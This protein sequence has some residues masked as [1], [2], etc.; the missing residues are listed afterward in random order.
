MNRNIR[1]KN[2]YRFLKYK[3]YWV[4]FLLFVVPIYAQGP[5]V[6]DKNYRPHPIGKNL[7]IFEDK[8]GDVNIDSILTGKYESLFF[9]SEEDV[10]SF[11][12]STS[13]FWLRF[14]LENRVTKRSP[15]VVDF[16][17]PNIHYIDYYQVSPKNEI[18]KS[19]H[20]GTMKPLSS[21]EFFYHH[22]IFFIQPSNNKVDQVYIRIESGTAKPASIELLSMDDFM[23]NAQSKAA[24]I[25][26][27]IGILLIMAGYNLFLFFSLKDK[28]YLYFSTFIAFFLF[29]VLSYKGVAQLY[30]WPDHFFWGKIAVPMFMVLSLIF[31]LKF[32][33]SFLQLKKY[34]IIFRHSFILLQVA[35]ILLLIIIPFTE[36]HF[37]ILPVNILILITSVLAVTV[38]VMAWRKGSRPAGFFLLSILFLL[39]STAMII[40]IRLN[41]I[42][43]N[44][45]TEEGIL[46]GGVSM[47]LLMSLALADRIKMLHSEKEEM[48][49]NLKSS[50]D[51][52]DTLI[53]SG[54]D[55][56]WEI[57]KIGAYTFASKNVQR[58]LGYEPSEIIGKTP[59]DLMPEKEAHEKKMIFDKI[60]AKRSPIVRLENIN[61]KKNGE[62]IILETNG[63]PFFDDNGNLLGYRGVDRDIT[64]ERHNEEL[65]DAIFQISQATDRANSLE[66]L[67]PEIHK[68]IMGIM[69]AQNFYISLYVEKIDMI[70]FP[71]FVDEYSKVAQSRKFGKG[72]TEYVLKTGKSYLVRQPENIKLKQDGEIVQM[73]QP[74]ALWLGVP[75]L[76][77]EKPIGVMAVQ[78]YTNPDAYS[79]K[80][81]KI[82]E[83]VSQQVALSIRKKQIEEQIRILS[84]SVEQSP[85]IVIITD[86]NGDIEYV[87]K[88]FVEVTGYGLDEVIGE[89]PRILKSDKT[90]DAVY[91]DMWDTITDGKEWQGEF[92]NKKKNGKIYFQASNVT[93]FTDEKGEVSHFLALAEDI[94]ESRHQEQIRKVMNNISDAVS[95]TPNLQEFYRVVHNELNELLDATNF[96]VGIYEEKTDSIIL[97]FSVDEKDAIE[98]APAA[99]TLS[100]YV[101]KNNQA[102]LLKEKEM[103]ELEAKGLIGHVGSDCKV[104]LGVP[105]KDDDQVTGVIVVQSYEDENAYDPGDLELMEFVAMQVSI[106]LKQKQIEDRIH[107]LSLSVEQSPATVMITDVDGHIEYVNRKFSQISGYESTEVIGKNPNIL[108]SGKMSDS[109][110][111]E[112]WSTIKNGKEWR[113]E[114]QNRKKNGD[115]YWE[116]IHISPIIND[117]GEIIRFLAVKEDISDRIELQDQLAQSQKMEAVGNLAGGI[118][119]DFNNLLTVI[120][121]YSEMA[122][123]KIEADTELHKDILAIQSA[124]EKA[125]DLTR[126]ILGFSRKQIYQPEIISLNNSITGLNEMIRRLIGEDIKIY[127]KLSSDLSPIKADARQIEQILINLIIN[128]R[129]AINLKTEKASEKKI[130]VETDKAFLDESFV[131]TH[132]GSQRGSHI[133]LSISDSGIGMS[134]EVKLNIFEPFFTTKEKEQG[135]GLGLATVYGIVKQNEGSIFVY[136]EPGKGS[137]FNIYWPASE[138][139]EFQFETK[140]VYEKDQFW[141]GESILYVEDD[142]AIQRFAKNALRKFGYTVYLAENGR[143]A[144]DFL[145]GNKQKIDLLIT[146]LIMPEMNGKELADQV[147]KI[148]PSI[149]VLFVSGY[150]DNHIVNGGQL[151][152]GVEFLQ[153]PYTVNSLLKK[154]RTMLENDSN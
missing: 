138:S 56:I 55:F 61:L 121:G 65:Q 109:F 81:L 104:W 99:K 15:W 152:K 46:V 28:S 63:M 120:N 69:D 14:S 105:L 76:I 21:R 67:F 87:N 20:T 143:K 90:E 57:N 147:K 89:N 150:T 117:N 54:T 75:L 141:G 40:F 39:I 4:F 94:S 116:L 100:G 5:I 139:N 33:D 23:N 74:S 12:F 27:L 83:F 126:R 93:P 11:S 34:K 19:L 132:L 88:K 66:A 136:S 41:L 70:E 49:K 127:Y 123:M 16:G 79:E 145:K 106:S 18:F 38:G 73:G 86:L 53:E 8:T 119:H 22:F 45:F 43:S 36:Y 64:E 78:H 17:F 25:G 98:K 133:V 29:F 130:T 153:K 52:L 31:F 135:T 148:L 68:I 71:Y 2:L 114:I 3:A 125:Q 82:M 146:D 80:E 140:K 24:M 107:V 131:S 103:D 113:G 85:G 35:N 10:P 37:F 134:E 154:I 124:S 51:R 122:M 101:I 84:R 9:Q 48:N 102:L 26:I 92:I 149:P 44:N 137:T 1:P 111:A 110:Y 30:L 58:L 97:P 6:L 151:D 128:A 91:K 60:L 108:K 47:V 142:P 129:D 96:F 118:A 144:M 62:P 32:T 115:L 42:S 50:L 72:W 112:M 95:T 13:A 77:D 7:E 59:F